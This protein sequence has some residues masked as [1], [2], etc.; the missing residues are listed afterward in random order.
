[1]LKNIGSNE[2][3]NN[4]EIRDKFD[5]ASFKELNIQCNIYKGNFYLDTFNYFPIT[6][7]YNTFLELFQRDKFQNNNHFFSE[8]FF[9]NFEKNISNFKEI[10]DVYLLGTNAANNYFSNLLNFLPRLFFNNDK[11][12]RIAIHRNSSL[13]FRKFIELIVKNLNKKCSFFYLDDNFYF[14]TNSKMPQFLNLVDSVKILKKFILPDNKKILDRK[15]Y[16]TRED[17]HYRKIVNESD[18]IPILRSKGYKVI[19]PQ[20]YD[21]DEQINIFNNADTIISPHGSNLSNIIFC[22][23]D[24]EI[25]EIGPSFNNEYEN[26]FENKYKYLAEL[27]NLKYKRI[28]TDTVK[29]EQ[30]S[31]LANKYINKNVLEKSNYYK[32]LIVKVKDFKNMS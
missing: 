2:I 18:I 16:V 28:L 31:E 21:I 22:K 3:K 9:N 25:F 26:Y 12:I 23:P 14:F 20:L 27:N 19:N 1:M 6:E 29:V 8:N 24:T 11:N 13:K 7:S 17:A 10:K 4:I 32:N 30:H 5:N 15:I